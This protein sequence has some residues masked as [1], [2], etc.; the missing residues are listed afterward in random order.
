MINITLLMIIQILVAFLGYLVVTT[1]T[2]EHMGL[3][4][5]AISSLVT[6]FVII[7]PAVAYYIGVTGF[8][9]NWFNRCVFIKL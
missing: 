4:V 7:V 6:A 9:M 8:L 1:R 5:Y 3:T 2:N